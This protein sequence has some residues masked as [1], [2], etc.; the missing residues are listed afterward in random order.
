MMIIQTTLYIHK[1]ILEML[2]RGTETTG[3]SRTAII[4]HLMQRVMSDNNKMLESYSRI[5]YQ[6]RD[7]KEN[8]HRLHITICEYEYE[9]YLDMRKFYKMSVSFI[10]AYA[11][12]RYLNAVVYALLDIDKN[13]DNY[14][15]RNYILI[16]KTL[17]GIICWQIYWGIPQKLACLVSDKEVIPLI[18][19]LNKLL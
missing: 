8:W 11:I 17:D 16:K 19:K 7:E 5:K 9:Y 15:Y 12:K 13:T 18:D 4:K 3:E 2:N 10:L 6:A 14:H 1:S